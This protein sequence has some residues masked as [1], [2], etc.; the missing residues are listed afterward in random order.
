MAFKPGQSGNVNGRPT[1]EEIAL[2][3]MSKGEL[4]AV[5]ELL[6]RAAP[7]A[8]KNIILAMSDESIPKKDRLKHSKD[9]YDMYVKA[10]TTNHALTRDSGQGSM[11]TEDEESEKAPVVEFRIAG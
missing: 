8:V 9:I 1:K 11:D 4:G 6:E 10:K 7:K 3:R 2:R 5:L